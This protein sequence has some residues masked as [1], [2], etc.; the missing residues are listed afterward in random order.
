MSQR[1]GSN[2]KRRADPAPRNRLLP[3]VVAAFVVLAACGGGGGNGDSADTSNNDASTDEA[4]ASVDATGGDPASTTDIGSLIVDDQIDDD[5]L[6]ALVTDFAALDADAQSDRVNELSGEVE[7]QMYELSGLAQELGSPEAVDDSITQTA[8]WLAELAQQASSSIGSAALEPQG[9][10][11]GVV[12]QAGGPDLSLG[13]FGGFLV[14]TLVGESAVTRTNDGTVGTR[15][16][17]EGIK[18]DASTDRVEVTTKHT[19]TDKAGVTTTLVTRNVVTPCPKADGTFEASAS[20]DTSSTINNGATGKRVTLDVTINGTVD[21][22]ADL[23]GY[24]LTS[25][26][27]YADFVASRGGFVDLTIKL[28]QAGSP[29]GEYTRGGGTVTSEI[30]ENASAL[31]TLMVVLAGTRLSATAK[32]G[33]ESGRCVALQPT[34]SAGPKGLQPSASVTINAAP[35]SKIDG[36]PTVGTVTAL[37]SGGGAGVDPSSTPVPADAEFTYQ[38]PGEKDKTGQV[39]L[40]ARSR[41]GVAKATIDFDTAGSPTVRIAGPVTYSLMG[42]EGTALVDLTLA[43]DP[44]GAYAG[45]ASLQVTGGF[46]FMQT[47]CTSA[48]WTESIDLMATLTTENDEQVLVI[49]TI[50]EAPRGTPVATECTTAGVRIPSRSS[51]LSSSL[52]GEVRIRVVSGDQAFVDTV[53]PGIVS[54]TVSVTV[55]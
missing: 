1:W 40:E 46:N 20:I 29:T 15:E 32:K 23:V 43:P 49:T 38:A 39:A 48:T 21:D 12:A 22:N 25:R 26:V 14:T 52:F 9:I 27:Q 34:V 17:S 44:D 13:L 16:L 31:S 33:W 54:G 10:R 35:R 2:P 37:L 53:T 30:V 7:R 41:R 19:F 11:S 55:T 28:P 6:N 45:T 51:L 50:G 5:A 47:S 36:T 3:L 8:E 42:A 4:S 18:I 24:D